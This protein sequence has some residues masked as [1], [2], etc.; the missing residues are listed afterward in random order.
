[1]ETPRYTFPVTLIP[2]GCPQFLDF[3]VDLASL[4]QKSLRFSRSF[5]EER[6]PGTSG[7]GRENFLLHCLVETEDGR[8]VERIRGDASPPPR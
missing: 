7:D 1:M 5:L 8:W 6:R 2:G 4:D 3:A